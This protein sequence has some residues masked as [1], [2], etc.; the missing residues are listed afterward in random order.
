MPIDKAVIPVAGLGTRLLPTTKAVPKEML[1]AGRLP[2]IHHVV[3]ELIAA[4]IRRILFVSSRSKVAIENHFD[5]YSQLLMA[6]ELDGRDAREVVR[7]DYRQ[8][9]IEFFFT[10]QQVPLGDTKPLGTGDAVAAAESFVGDS[11]FVVAF[12]DSI[13]HG[14]EEPSLL[15]RMVASHDHHDA[16]CT[17]GAWN[18]SP[19]QVSNYGILVPRE[20]EAAEAD[21]RLQD[22]IEKP[23]AGVTSS[24]LAISARYV[25]GAE[26]FAQI[27]AVAPAQNGEIYLT[28]AIRRLIKNGR[29]VRAVRVGEG[30][31]RY[32]IGNHRAYFRTFVDF[33]LEDPEWGPD[34]MDYLRERIKAEDVDSP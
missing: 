14:G 22:V 1:P 32:D 13:I 3:E 17:I 27:R 24:R 29:E 26:I 18:V 10:R 2:I 15:Q 5:D 31:Q 28:D 9:G 19:D 21:C 7:F 33:A 16:A 12:G 6:L 4:G 23:A 34:L 8:R 25:F 20:Q 30:E 11:D